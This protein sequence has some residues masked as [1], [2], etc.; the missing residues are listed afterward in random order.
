VKNFY[1]FFSLIW[2]PSWEALP[3]IA[4]TLFIHQKF[5]KWGNFGLRP[6]CRNFGCEKN[7]NKTNN[8]F[9]K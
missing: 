5:K 8:N 1:F 2:Y 7:I 4:A 3:S 9:K 6:I